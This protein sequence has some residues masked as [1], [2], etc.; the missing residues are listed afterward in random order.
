M[1]KQSINI[2]NISDKWIKK[3]ESLCLELS[4][5]YVTKQQFEHELRNLLAESQCPL[6]GL[7]YKVISGKP[8]QDIHLG[9]QQP[10]DSE[11]HPYY[12]EDNRGTK[13]EIHNWWKE[14][15]KERSL[16]IPELLE[17]LFESYWKSDYRT[18]SAGYIDL[19]R[20]KK[21]VQLADATIEFET[22]KDNLAIV[23]NCDLDNF[24]A[25]NT[26]FTTKGGDRVIREFGAC[27][28]TCCMDNA[29]LFHHGGDEFALLVPSASPEDGLM[30]AYTL[31]K[32][33]SKHDF[34]T[35]DLLISVS[36]G[37]SCDI[38]GQKT[39]NDLKED[40]EEGLKLVKDQGDAGKGNARFGGVLPFGEETISIDRSLKLGH[41]I[42]K[43]GVNSGAPFSNV[44]INTISKVTNRAINE[45]G[46]ESES[47]RQD[48]T[49]FLDWAKLELGDITKSRSWRD[50]GKGID[51]SADLSALDIC[52]AII[53]GAWAALISQP[54]P[55]SKF[56]S[57]S[58]K[59]DVSNNHAALLRDGGDMFWTSGTTGAQ[60]ITYDLGEIWECSADTELSAANTEPSI[61]IF[62]GHDECGLPK[63]L[64]PEPILVDDRPTKGGG[65]PDFW[66]AAI[67]KL[68]SQLLSNDTI[69][70]VYL[71]GDYNYAESVCLKLENI[72]DWVKD[73]EQLAFKTGAKVSEINKAVERLEGN[74]YFPRNEE[75]LLEL[76]TEDIRKK[77]KIQKNEMLLKSESRTPFLHK[78]VSLEGF[79]LT[80]QDGCKVNTVAEAFPVALDIVRL[81][82]EERPSVDEAGKRMKELRNFKIHLSTPLQNMIPGFYRKD[83]DSLDSYFQ[84]EFVNKN[85]LF[86][87]ELEKDDQFNIV[88]NEVTKIIET[89]Q[90]RIA[91]RRA[92]L[93]MPNNVQQGLAPLGLVSVQIMPRFV[94][95]KIKI[96]FSY[97]WRTVEA[98]VGL[99]YSLYGSVR[100]SEYILG[101]IVKQLSFNKDNLIEVGEVTYIAGS[102]HMFLD[103]YGQSIARQIVNDVS[104]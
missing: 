37:I 15:V 44:W 74:V 1:T 3:L 99:P 80:N 13:C 45:H 102:L 67:A 49:A 54:L 33:V 70:K 52:Y 22:K 91:T 75:S 68:I 101:E 86:S 39:F 50:N 61:L 84:K 76:L 90:E 19:K 92:I 100:Y 8:Y 27:I 43:I 9:S 6:I 17:K 96:H 41:C 57:A 11:M 20:D 21:A 38:N 59:C 60:S 24:K 58:I 30:L 104:Y 4:S 12:P 77:R 82:H 71:L 48:I 10:N 46:I 42:S 29:I 88:I 35:E 14:D 95:N 69:T 28:E 31:C 40:A 51:H 87:R 2:M 36:V 103:D 94:K 97:T 89:S 93:I 81:C 63:L 79:L 83:E 16:K 32:E 73:N 7:C 78:S 65:L 62:I 53:H 25:V 66:E 47:V 85:G 34:K 98:L 5:R 26:R 55:A 56:L 72:G 23:L 64:F 18:E